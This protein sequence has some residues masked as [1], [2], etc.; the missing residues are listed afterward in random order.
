MSGYCDS[1]RP[2]GD[3]MR[4]ASGVLFI[5]VGLWSVLGGSCT[6]IAGK[7]AGAGKEI[8]STSIEKQAG[9]DLDALD[10]ALQQFGNTDGGKTAKVWTKYGVF[11]GIFILIAGLL[12]ISSGIAYLLNKFRFLGFVATGLGIIAECMF[13]IFLEFNVAGLIKIGV[14]VFCG[15]AGIKGK[16]PSQSKF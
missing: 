5:L 1:L 14:L 8:V 2:Q 15:V 11:I 4:I 9:T 12:A 3:Q 10:T 7:D 6:F 16:S 13:F